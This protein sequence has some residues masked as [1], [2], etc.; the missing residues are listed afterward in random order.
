MNES[1]PMGHDCWPSTPI[2]RFYQ[3]E[4]RR[5]FM[6]ANDRDLMP[7]AWILTTCKTD[8]CLNA[9]HMVV[10]APTRIKYPAGVCVYCGMPA[11]TKDHLLPRGKTGEARRVLVATVPACADCNSRISDYPDPSVTARRR[12]AQ[13]SIRRAKR[14]VL[15]AKVWTLDE[16]SEM[17]RN[18]R[19]FIEQKARERESVLARLA[20]PEDVFYDLRAFQHSG[21][22]DPVALGL[23]DNPIQE[24]QQ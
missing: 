5:V 9:Q 10:H 8:G 4:A 19:T 22:D 7:W 21:I 12:V 16:L 20:W 2:A 24:G 14:S 6:I 15:S 23:C 11:G 18:L 17:G 1:E 13:A 3:P